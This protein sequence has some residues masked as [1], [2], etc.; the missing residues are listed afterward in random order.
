MVTVT[1]ARQKLGQLVSRISRGESQVIIT[2]QGCPKAALVNIDWL[3]D[4]IARSERLSESESGRPWRLCGSM[5]MLVSP[6]KIEESIREIRRQAR[7][8]LE[9][10]TAELAA[11]LRE[12]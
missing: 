11:S 2:Q 3:N 9:R 12:E 10:S 8:A 5:E 1:E 7:E 4:L 6:E